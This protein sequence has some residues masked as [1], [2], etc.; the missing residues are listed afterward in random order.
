MYYAKYIKYKN[1]Y[2]KL[3]YQLGGTFTN[4]PLLR[5]EL[6]KELN[7][8]I[9]TESTTLA[10]EEELRLLLQNNLVGLKVLKSNSKILKP[11]VEYNK[12]FRSNPINFYDYRDKSSDSQDSYILCSLYDYWK[13]LF[14]LQKKNVK[15]RRINIDENGNVTI[16]LENIT[17]PENTSENLKIDNFINLLK[18][19]LVGIKILE[20]K[21]EL[22]TVLKDKKF[23]KFN[24]LNKVYFYRFTDT[25]GNVY[26]LCSLYDYYEFLSILYE[27][28]EIEEVKLYIK[29]E[30]VDFTLVESDKIYHL[31]PKPQHM[32]H[33]SIPLPIVNTEISSYDDLINTLS[34]NPFIFTD[35][36]SNIHTICMYNL[37]I[38][39][40]HMY[41]IYVNGNT[42]GYFLLSL[43]TR[44]ELKKY[45][46]LPANINLKEC[47][48]Y[49][50]GEEIEFK[51]NE[52]LVKM[53]FDIYNRLKTEG[54]YANRLKRGDSTIDDK[55]ID[56]LDSFLLDNC[57]RCIS[58]KDIAFNTTF[59]FLEEEIEQGIHL[60]KDILE[61]EKDF[62]KNK[63][64]LIN[65][66]EKLYLWRYKYENLIQLWEY[67][68]SELKE[69]IKKFREELLGLKYC[70]KRIIS[71]KLNEKGFK[72]D[73]IEEILKN[74]AL[75]YFEDD[76]NVNNKRLLYENIEQ[77][78]KTD[79][80]VRKS[81]YTQ[82]MK[83][84]L[85]KKDS[86]VNIDLEIHKYRQTVLLSF[87][88]AG[89]YRDNQLYFFAMS[90]HISTEINFDKTFDPLAWTFKL[91]K[92]FIQCLVLKDTL[93]FPFRIINI[94]LKSPLSVTLNVDDKKRN[95][96]KFCGFL[97]TRFL[98][99]YDGTKNFD[100]YGRDKLYLIYGY[101]DKNYI[102][103]SGKTYKPYYY[104][105]NSIKF[106]VS[107]LPYY[108]TFVCEINWLYY[109]FILKYE[110]IPHFYKYINDYC[111]EEIVVSRFSLEEI[112]CKYLENGYDI[113]ELK[114]LKQVYY[115][116]R[117]FEENN[118]MFRETPFFKTP[119]EIEN[120]IKKVKEKSKLHSSL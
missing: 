104:T 4:K 33:Q 110:S 15:I 2:L 46:S 50:K 96:Q 82:E 55:F 106:D 48:L 86:G 84:L 19:N 120:F 34:C 89:K 1:K 74:S 32:F 83:R 79:E 18:E 8:T 81:K 6:V 99:D 14:K 116:D 22:L 56:K 21:S 16:K 17:I 12:Q 68:F 60:H 87:G 39:T 111:E 112:E 30:K 62:L 64:E 69:E 71:F 43:F 114:K 98:D 41:V 109:T 75:C 107:I 76:D 23:I 35:K 85:E 25:D 58:V 29:D 113:T 53:M 90:W 63:F 40:I 20:S 78:D 115:N 67:N 42:N 119:E 92:L 31:I 44:Y 117:Y 13:I 28:I 3:K 5:T 59:F 73:T 105:A 9:P 26:I 94:G 11:L 72:G 24:K 70:H 91:N 45:I 77:I 88:D 47:R 95:P 52:E 118:Y 51:L 36:Q 27:H 38:G 103:S 7:S 101:K 108:R 102:D 65:S 80:F 61:M 10:S 93:I 37:F 49:R 100:E 66:N 57:K 97:H 54:H